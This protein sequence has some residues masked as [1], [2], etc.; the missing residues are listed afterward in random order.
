LVN[1]LTPL[2]VVNAHE[3]VNE[4]GYCKIDPVFARSICDFS[5]VN[6]QLLRGYLAKD[7][8]SRRLILGR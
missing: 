3:F 8:S 7:K 6:Q 1:P 2:H 4:A 5:D